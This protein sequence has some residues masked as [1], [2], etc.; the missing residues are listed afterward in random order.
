MPCPNGV[1]IPGNFDFFNYAHLFDDL[2]GA[3]FKYGVF[4]TEGQR[5]GA[6]IACGVCE[7]KC[8]QKIEI[9]QWMPKVTALL[10]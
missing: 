3:R 10:A 8:P 5:S 7:E 9:S 4:L 2:Q 6:C 1:N